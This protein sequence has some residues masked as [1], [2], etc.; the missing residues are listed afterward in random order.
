MLDK[1]LK[2]EKSKFPEIT[3]WMSR[4]DEKFEQQAKRLSVQQGPTGNTAS[5]TDIK[6]KKA[7]AKKNAAP[8]PAK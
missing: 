3:E 4:V 7:G 2:L 8:A 5:P 1:S 6:G